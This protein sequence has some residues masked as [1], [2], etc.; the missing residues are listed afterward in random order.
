MRRSAGDDLDDP[1]FLQLGKGPDHVARD[2][3]RVEFERA[4]QRRV[5]EPRQLVERRLVFCPV[6]LPPCHL[7]PSP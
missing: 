3:L 5:V 1:V 2:F 4:G 7:H 6:D